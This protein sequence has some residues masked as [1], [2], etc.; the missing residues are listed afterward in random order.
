MAQP[1]TAP[2]PQA[3]LFLNIG[4]GLMAL[5]LLWWF[6]Y[7]AQYEG[8]F[9]LLG[10]KLLCITGTTSEC[11]FFQEQMSAAAAPVPTY[12][13]VLWWCGTIAVAIGLFMSR[14]EAKG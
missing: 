13:P 12:Y 5:S 11:S 6:A 4:L 7:Y 9:D 3:R 8:A 10:L 2:N 14:R 1:A